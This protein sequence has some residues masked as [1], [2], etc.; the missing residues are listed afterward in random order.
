MKKSDDPVVVEQ[1]Y[2]APPA[3]VWQSITN[4]E[5]MHQWYFE[6]IPS[7]KPKIGFETEFNIHSNGR[8]F[9]HQWKITEVVT[10]KKISYDWKFKNYPGDLSVTFELIEKE[11]STLLRLTVT[12][13]EDFQDDIPEFKRE[14]CLGGWE[15]FLKERLKKYLEGK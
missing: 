1:L 9:L 5:Q 13:R 8:D 3:R 15:Y 4:L 6:N 2:N 14:S 12:V 11:K 10:N 7:F